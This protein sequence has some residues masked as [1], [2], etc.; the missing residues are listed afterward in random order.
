MI[1]EPRIWNNLLS[2]QPL[3]FNM[4]GEKT[5]DPDLATRFLEKV[6][7]GTV[8]RVDFEYS[9]RRGQPDRSAFDV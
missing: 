8:T 5:D 1:S 3:C 6:L 9:T 4:F 2:S 7:P